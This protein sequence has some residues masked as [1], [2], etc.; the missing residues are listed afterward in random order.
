MWLQQTQYRQL[1]K[2]WQVHDTSMNRI[3]IPDCLHAN[4]RV[5]NHYHGEFNAKLRHV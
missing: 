3:H 5:Q 4:G 1:L 2:K